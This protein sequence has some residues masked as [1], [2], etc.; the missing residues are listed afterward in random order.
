MNEIAEKNSLLFASIPVYNNFYDKST[1]ENI[2]T[3]NRKYGIN[4]SNR[5]NIPGNT[6]VL[7]YTG[8]ASSKLDFGED[9][10]YEDDGIKD[11]FGIGHPIIPTELSKLFSTQ[12][13]D[14]ISYQ[15]PVFGVTYG[16]QNQMYFK[17]ISINMDE[18]KVTDY[19]I[20]N[21]IQISNGGKNGDTE[22][23]D[24]GI[25]QDIYSIYSN[26]SYTCTVE[27][28]GCINIMPMMYF[29][30][31]NI[32]MFR[33]FY[34]I[35]SVSHSIVPGNMTTKFTG[36]RVS[37]NHIGEVKT[38][39]DYQSLIDKVEIGGSSAKSSESTNVSCDNFVD[40]K[41]GKHFML[42]D[43]TT[44]STTAGKTICNLPVEGEDWITLDE[45]KKRLKEVAENIIDPLWDAWVKVGLEDGFNITS[46]FR[47]QRTQAKL[48]GKPYGEKSSTKKTKK[49]WSAHT[50][51]YAVD[52]QSRSENNRATFKKFVYNWL[53]TNNI[54]I[55]QFIDEQSRGVEH[56]KIAKVENGGWAHIGFKRYTKKQRGEFK[57]TKTGGAP[58]N[59]IPDGFYS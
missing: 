4:D 3:P 41:I 11:I 51:G 6:Y 28:L 39:F 15:I 1:I 40:E 57:W 14:E 38:V 34:M 23:Y 16:K 26:R 12:E 7:M 49:Y 54:K 53:K 43:F 2:F 8:E 20:A 19:S 32:P 44:K 5:R 56:Q 24:V 59:D 35:I 25:G 52:I 48:N 31:N 55:D 58:Y 27:M 45:L 42:S 18:P 10:N 22:G 37:K 36:V 17:N 9:S 21:L 33:G 29:Q 46:G 50:Y 47:S 30:L 13:D